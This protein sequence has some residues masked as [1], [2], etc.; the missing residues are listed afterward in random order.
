MQLMSDALFDFSL[1]SS[2]IIP[3]QKSS[4]S[5]LKTTSPVSTVVC[6]F[7]LTL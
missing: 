7:F 3:V 1:G 6:N 5:L 2:G 4:T